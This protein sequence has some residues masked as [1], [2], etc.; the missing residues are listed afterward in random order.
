MKQD[1]GTIMIR[2]VKDRIEI[3]IHG[4]K[5]ET[6][7]KL[8]DGKKFEECTV[9]AVSYTNKQ[10]LGLV[11]MLL[12][13]IVMKKLLDEAD[14]LGETEVLNKYFKGKSSIDLGVMI[15]RVLEDELERD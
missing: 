10:V 6:V 4:G 2:T 15:S 8:R 13:E 7:N 3:A 1:N 5:L 11:S 14:D 9:V 12:E